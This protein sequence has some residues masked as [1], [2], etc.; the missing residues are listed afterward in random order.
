MRTETSK[1]VAAFQRV[2]TVYEES[3]TLL[4]GYADCEDW[5]F[6]KKKVVRENLLKKRASTWA[7]NILRT[8]KNRFLVDSE[9]LPNV[10]EISKFVS[11]DI[12]KSSKVQ[13]LYQ[14]V[15]ESD[16]LVDRLVIELVRPLVM[17][18]GACRLTKQMYD[19]FMKKVAM[20]HPEIDS[21]SPVVYETWQRKFFAFLRHSR[22]MEKAPSLK[23]RKPLVRVEPF[24]FFLYGLV[25]RG[26][27]GLEVIRSR[28]W[29]RYFMSEDD[30][31]YALSSAQERGW[32]QH[33]RMGS[34]VELTTSYRSLERWLNGAL[35]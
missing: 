31:E 32:L 9:L 12:P 35:G 17:R 30:V 26:F 10:K 7:E 11:V 22:I 27:F 13:A 2:G 5:S 24:T 29:Q 4:N 34:I 6:V 18:Y 14:Y 21:W 3:L 8:V 1:Y 16:P 19:E 15:C 28:L 20:D 33:R 25:D 23:I